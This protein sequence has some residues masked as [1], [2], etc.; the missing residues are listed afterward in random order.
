ML[1]ALV[2]IVLWFSFGFLA[3][4][5]LKGEIIQHHLSRLWIRTIR[6]EDREILRVVFVTGFLGL[7]F[8]VFFVNFSG[9]PNPWGNLSFKLRYP[10]ELKK[11]QSSSR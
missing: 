4:G 10:K 2:G 7:L 6:K 5:L 3:Y 11:G 8:S 9:K 1:Y